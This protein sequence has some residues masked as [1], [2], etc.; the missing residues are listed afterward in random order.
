M[1]FGATSAIAESLA[2]LLVADADNICLVARNSQAMAELE[3]DLSV[4]SNANI[5]SFTYDFTDL[6]GIKRL[7]A[8]ILDKIPYIDLAVIAY[9][10]LPVQD[11]CEH[12]LPQMQM[13]L[14]TNF[15]SVIWVGL[16]IVQHMQEHKKGT[17]VVLSSV[18]GDRGRQ[19]NY[20]YG[21]AKGAVSIFFDGLRNQCYGDGVKILTVKPGFVD[22]PMT[23]GFKKG[24][25][26]VKPDK[27]ARD[28]ISA[29]HKGKDVLY[30]PWYWR[31]IM[32]IIKLIPEFIFKRLKL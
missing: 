16:N 27:I 8:Q 28:I 3:K 22:T 2:R 15:T 4:R 24:F 5:L 1:I 17:L 20:I 6:S 18:A 21:S 19:S 31:W 13:A 12:E 11:S 10:T 29:L 7:Q 26:W 30:T 9:G 32:L 14:T 25:L 23:D